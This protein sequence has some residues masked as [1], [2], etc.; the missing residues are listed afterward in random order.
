MVNLH[1]DLVT[2][3]KYFWWFTAPQAW[4]N[5][6]FFFF[7]SLTVLSAYFRYTLQ[8]EWK[9]KS[10]FISKEKFN[11]FCCYP[12]LDGMVKKRCEATVPLWTRFF[13]FWASV[14][15]FI[16]YYYSFERWTGHKMVLFS[17]QLSAVSLSLPFNSVL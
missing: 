9:N 11:I 15:H 12:A 2:I 13:R 5:N 17:S 10:S 14:T 1:L 7:F 8:T 6:N 3:F 16:K 4:M